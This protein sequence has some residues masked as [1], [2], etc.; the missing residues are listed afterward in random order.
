MTWNV[1][2]LQKWPRGNDRHVCDCHLQAMYHL[3]IRRQR[4]K[5]TSFVFL[6]LTLLISPASSIWPFPPKRFAG[7]SLL[8]AGSIGLDSDCRVVAFGDFNGDQLWVPV[9][10]WLLEC[11]LTVQYVWSLDV[12]SLGSD[13][14]TL[15]VYFWNHGK[16]ACVHSH[17]VSKIIHFTTEDFL[18]QKS[19][20]FKHPNRIYNVVPGDFTHDGK[21]DLLVMSESSTTD[22]MD[23]FL[24]RGSPTGGFG[25]FSGPVIENY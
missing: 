19:A 5:R 21:L 1:T 12:L 7:N 9:Y 13:Q 24:Y 18:F 16:C 6:T 22:Q 4:R 14:E 3:S 8:R 23:L 10:V 20:S 11:I 17:T 15:S 2:R 25:M